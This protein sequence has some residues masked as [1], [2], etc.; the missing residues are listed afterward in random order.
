MWMKIK[1][2]EKLCVLSRSS[3]CGPATPAQSLGKVIACDTSGS[4]KQGIQLTKLTE[5]LDPACSQRHH[6]YS[7]ACLRLDAMLLS[8]RD[9]PHDSAITSHAFS[10]KTV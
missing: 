6:S 2:C 7:E 3:W 9:Y 8:F 5:R 4:M 1:S 10:G